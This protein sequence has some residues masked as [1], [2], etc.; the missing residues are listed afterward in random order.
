MP[1]L[2]LIFATIILAVFG[3][4]SMKKGMNNIGQISLTELFSK[5]LFSVLYEKFVFIGVVLFVI[6]AAFWLVV[7][8]QEELSFA[9]PLIGTGYIITA[10]L[11][12]IFFNENLTMFRIFGIVLIAIGAYFVVTKW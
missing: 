5:K 10:I 11:S 6:S 3:Q 8:S 12:K 2:A 4:L 1:V 7:L 9:Y